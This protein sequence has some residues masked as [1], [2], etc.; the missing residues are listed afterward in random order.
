MIRKEKMKKIISILLFLTIVACTTT[1]Q[2]EQK[3]DY[4]AIINAFKYIILPN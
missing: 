3:T 2:S 1:N 4:N